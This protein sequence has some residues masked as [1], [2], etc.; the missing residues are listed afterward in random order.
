MNDSST[1]SS[2]ASHRAPAAVDGDW[3]VS[4]KPAN[5]TRLAVERTVPFGLLT[6]S[7]VVIWHQLA[8]TTR[9]S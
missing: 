7:P 6:Q 8:V 1:Y 9:E 2:T 5:R 4:A 3:P